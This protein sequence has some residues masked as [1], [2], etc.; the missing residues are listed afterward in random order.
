MTKKNGK[1]PASGKDYQV[2]DITLADWGRKEISVA[3]QEMPGP[4][5]AGYADGHE[6]DDAHAIDEHRPAADAG[7]HDGVHGVAQGIEDG[8]DLVGNV[9]VNRPDIA[10]WQR[11]VLGKTAIAVDADNVH[12]FADVA[13][14]GAA[15]FAGAAADVALA[16]DAVA[17]AGSQHGRA[18]RLD[19]ADEFVAGGDADGDAAGA[20]GVPFIDVAVG[21]ADAGVGDADEHVAGADGRQ[22]YMGTKIQ[23]SGGLEFLEGDHGW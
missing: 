23:A 7:G 19:D 13:V 1:K 12:F 9:A 14:A 18:Q 17:D 8:G 16:A 5:G 10:L 21:A 11:E 4:G 20:P 15:G 3:E 2:R 22:R 6:A